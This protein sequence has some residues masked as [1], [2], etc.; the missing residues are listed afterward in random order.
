MAGHL[1]DSAGSGYG[2]LELTL[3]NIANALLVKALTAGL[4]RDLCHALAASAD[5]GRIAAEFMAAKASTTVSQRQMLMAGMQFMQ[6]GAVCNMQQQ[7][8]SGIGDVEV[9]SAQ[10]V[11]SSTADAGGMPLKELLLLL[12]RSSGALRVLVLHTLHLRL[13]GGNGLCAGQDATATASGQTG[14]AAVLL[15]MLQNAASDS[16]P[17]LAREAAQACLAAV[18]LNAHINGAGTDD[19]LGS[20]WME[21]LMQQSLQ[22]ICSSWQVESSG[23]RPQHA[24][25]SASWFGD[26][27]FILALVS[28]ASASA[29]NEQ[30]HHRKPAWLAVGMK[31]A[32]EKQQLMAVLCAAIGAEGDAGSGDAAARAA[33]STALLQALLQA[34]LLKEHL[35]RLHNM[36]M[37]QRWQ[38]RV[39]DEQH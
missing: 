36:L 13:Q 31:E 27:L 1:A 18:V 37:Q 26:A 11:S 33:V 32:V 5:I 23:L 7:Q 12:A 35:P 39:L 21:Q 22:R 10:Q 15:S 6:Y 30:H 2:T 20:G 3:L 17:A 28:G 29:D 34:G 4:D 9:R 19:W 38:R 16:N 14:A 24:T 8:P 25:G